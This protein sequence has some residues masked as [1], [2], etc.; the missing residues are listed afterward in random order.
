MNKVV[1]PYYAPCAHHLSYPFGER[2]DAGRDP[3]ESRGSSQDSSPKGQ[4]KTEA[5]GDAMAVSFRQQ[6]MIVPENHALLIL[7][8]NSKTNAISI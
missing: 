7:L 8:A 6:C 5:G 1:R 2:R 4:K 3:Q